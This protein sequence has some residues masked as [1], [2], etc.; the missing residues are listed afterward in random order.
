MAKLNLLWN[1]L[2]VAYSNDLL[3]VGTPLG[4]HIQTLLVKLFECEYEIFSTLFC[5][6]FDFKKER[7]EDFTTYYATPLGLQLKSNL[8]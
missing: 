6:I 5:E 7:R 4:F 2:G 3:S 8:L 1:P